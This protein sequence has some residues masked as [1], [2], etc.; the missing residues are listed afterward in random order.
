MRR[1][2]VNVKINGVTTHT[3][4]FDNVLRALYF[5]K[6]VH[7][8]H[9]DLRQYGCDCRCYMKSTPTVALTNYVTDTKIST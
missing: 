6:F 8:H 2:I 9:D 5:I 3:E 1:I 4:Y 7:S